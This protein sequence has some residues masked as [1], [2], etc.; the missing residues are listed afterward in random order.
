MRN[1]NNS[2][3]THRAINTVKNAQRDVACSQVHGGDSDDEADDTEAEWDGDVPEPLARLVRMSAHA[4]RNDR[5]EH[6]RRRAQQER[7]RRVVAHRRAECREE[8][9]EGERDH[10]TGER[11]REPPHLPVRECEHETVH[12]A[13][14]LGLLLIADTDVLLH[15]ALGQA[16]LLRTEPRVRGRGEVRE[17]EDGEHGE[18]HREA[19]FD[20]E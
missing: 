11:E 2:V 10:Q 1:L 14:G 17:D 9:I 18:E 12:L 19:A 8:R 4:E 5:R 6:P 7:D 13:R 16:H 15:A 3:S 20:E